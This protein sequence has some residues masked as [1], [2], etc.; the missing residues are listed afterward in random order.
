MIHREFS[1]ISTLLAAACC[2]PGAWAAYDD[3]GVGA[4]AT[5]MG[6]AF[7]AVADD[8]YSVYY[9]PA[10]LGVLDRGQ[11][12]TT[13]SKLFMGLSDGSNLQN[14]FLAFA[15]PLEQGKKGTCALAWNYFTL[16]GLYRETSVYGAYGRQIFPERAPSGLFAGA[17]V[18]Y[19]SRGVGSVPAADNAFNDAG[20]A[21]QG[22]DPVLQKGGKSNFDFDIG[23]LYRLK[24]RFT[25]G[26][27]VQHLF[28][29]DIAISDSDND[30]LGRNIKLGAAYQTGWAA[31]S[32]DLQFL[33]APDRAIDRVLTLAAEKWLPTLM[34][35]AFGVRGSVGFGDR[36]YRQLTAGVS[37][38]IHCLQVDYGF[39]IP[40]GTVAGTAGTH[41]MGLTFR[42]GRP[43]G[44]EPRFSEAI[45]ENMREL[46]GAGAPEFRAQAEDIALYKRTA[47]SGF[48]RQAREDSSAAR[49][50]EARSKLSQALEINPNDA[51]I[52]RSL[53]RMTLAASLF[54]ELPDFR[55]DAAEAALYEGILDY[56]AGRDLSAL[57]KLAYAQV[58]SPSD[59]RIEKLLQALEA[60]AGLAR[61][62]SLPAPGPAPTL[63]REK[64]AAAA[65]AL[66]EVA[67]R[68]G[69][70][71]KVLRLAQQALDAAPESVLAHK[72]M[73][74]AFYAKKDYPMALRSLQL[75]HKLETEPEAKRTLKSYID[76]LI[77]LMDRA[78]RESRP[79][80]EKPPK[81]AASPTEMQR[82]YEAGVDL[83]AQGRLGEAA[84][85][86]RKILDMAPDNSSA[87][88]ALQRIQ[89]DGFQ[90]G[91]R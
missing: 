45:L 19:L 55:T 1:F 52:A 31:F 38:R 44:A 72:R 67:L 82:M 29:P 26:L 12:A 28:E 86:F 70:Y 49:F 37:Y 2:A 8:V 46:A 73:A 3:V 81:A 9:N 57:K 83:Y 63:G 21:D 16:D 30:P 77:S 54:P 14:S 42:F 10:G 69:D 6:N 90:G 33:K 91:A 25:M 39:T 89:A 74:T 15:Q 40:L 47:Q 71:D 41:R 76:A 43:R 75:A 34:Y 18:K 53:E 51:A 23:L 5:G 7:T 13:Y 65:L 36:D 85:M 11:L 59:E 4:R 22:P 27:D 56:A 87:K 64:V 84:S 60:G 62:P 35:G 79:S 78:V 20:A 68:D 66:M 61:A 24:P 88:R 32:S 58:L 48:L 17:A 50:A 80:F